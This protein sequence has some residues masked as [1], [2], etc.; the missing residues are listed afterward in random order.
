MHRGHPGA[1]ILGMASGRPQKETPRPGL[2]VTW[3]LVGLEGA[4]GV[5]EIA[6]PGRHNPGERELGR[7][8]HQL[9]PAANGPTGR[10]RD[11]H[12]RG[13]RSDDAHGAL[14]DVPLG[15]DAPAR[16]FFRERAAQDRVRIFREINTK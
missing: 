1:R 14:G 7:L 6:V 13:V 4:S 8:G 3:G 10:R 15:T 12:V 5:D 2:K 9:C 16:E 11:L